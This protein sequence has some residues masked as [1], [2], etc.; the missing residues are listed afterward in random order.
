MPFSAR[1]VLAKLLRA[2][3]VEV[4]QSGSH[5]VLRLPRW[6]TNLRCHASGRI[7]DWN[8]SQD[9]EASRTFRR[10]VSRFVAELVDLFFS[11]RLISLPFTPHRIIFVARASTFCGIVTPICFAVLRFITR[12][13][14]VGYSTGSSAPGVAWKKTLS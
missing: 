4:R 1:E 7:A 12:S 6:P 14:F 2:G 10:T 9:P 13:N 5:K 8:V 3:F 11:P